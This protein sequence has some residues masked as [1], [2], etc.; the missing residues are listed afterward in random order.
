MYYELEDDTYWPDDDGYTYAEAESAA[1]AMLGRRGI[2]LP[3]LHIGRI[4]GM[5]FIALALALFMGLHILADINSGKAQEIYVADVPL[6]APVK[7]SAASASLASLASEPAIAVPY[8]RFVL[9]QGPHGYSYG[10]MAIDIA[11]GKGA[12][13]MSP[14][15]GEV[16]HKY[17]DGVGNTVLVI[18][19]E[20][21]EVML[22]HGIYN[23]NIGKQVSIGDPIG[24]ESNIGYTTD[25]QGRLCTNRDCGYHTHLNIV[26]KAT[27]Q[28]VNPLNVLD[29]DGAGTGG[30]AQD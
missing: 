17:I 25:M 6:D 3:S 15:N 4:D 13:I 27:G 11:A 29:I 21:Y 1:H 5:I 7:A 8:D 14:I 23:V 26:D 30:G 18:E 12:V 22:L 19:N 20:Q 16:T 28:N 9:T 2:Q 10:H 24:T